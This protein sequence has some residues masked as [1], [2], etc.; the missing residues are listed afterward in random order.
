[1]PFGEL[2]DPATETIQSEPDRIY[3]QI[4]V[5]LW[6]AGLVERD[7]ISGIQMASTRRRRVRAGQFLVSR[8]DARN[9]AV[10]VVPDEL[11]GA[12]VT[13]DF[14]VFSVR[15]EIMLPQYLNW[16]TKTG[17]FV[18]LC[19]RASEG[20]TNRV[21]LKIKTFLGMTIPV[22]PLEEQRRI[23]TLLENIRNANSLSLRLSEQSSGLL[24]SAADLAFQGKL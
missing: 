8:I 11:D 24:Q 12:L 17:R 1:L 7:Q 2:L 3:R 14:P 13:N 19:V 16:L 5:R 23:V 20:T 6:G 22:P 10:G 4:S 21:R 9:G 15:Q 18:H